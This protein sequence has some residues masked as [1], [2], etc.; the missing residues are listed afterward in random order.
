VPKCRRNESRKPGK[1]SQGLLDGANA[2]F[3]EVKG[4]RDEMKDGPDEVKPALDA[5]TR[6]V[7]GG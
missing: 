1:R 5:V 6:G 4:V 3:N 2:D 7:S